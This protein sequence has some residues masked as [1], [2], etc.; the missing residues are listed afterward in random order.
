[1][2]VFFFCYRESAI[3]PKSLPSEFTAAKELFLH[4]LITEKRFAKNTVAAYGSDIDLFFLFLINLLQPIRNLSGIEE[5]TVQQFLKQCNKKH[6]S[7][8]TNARRIS[9]LKRFFNY[10]QRQSLLASNPMAGISSPKASKSLPKG[11]SLVEV[12]KLLTSPS[13]RTPLTQRNHTMLQLLYSTGMRVSELVQLPLT[14]LNLSSCFIRVTGK[15]NKERLIPFGIPAQEA[16]TDY[17]DSARPLI[18]KGKRSNALF[19]TNH[20]KAMTRLRFWQILK[21]AAQAA[22]ITKNISPHSLRHSFATHLLTHGADLRSV[23]MMLGHSDITTT[24]IYTHVDE[25]RLKSIH[26]KFHPRG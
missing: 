23:Q 12:D 6:L 17:L 5:K 22:G 20:G 24:Q 10:L 4:Y 19:V 3:K 9:A 1:M 18:M 7:H 25:G 16:L 13:L 15:G 8:R 14:G 21:E 26:Q 2:G 11:M